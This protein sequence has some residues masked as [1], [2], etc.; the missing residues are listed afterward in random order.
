MKLALHCSVPYDPEIP[1][2]AI[3]YLKGFLEENGIVTKN[4]YWNLILFEDMQFFTSKL[5]N[6]FSE[7]E[8]FL[9]QSSIYILSKLIK[10]STYER[11]VLDAYLKNIFPEHII[12][13]R[14]E[15]IVEKIEAYIDSEKLY[16]CD[17]AG[18][19]VNT[20]QWL[21]DFTIIKMMKKANPDLKV[22]IGGLRT[23][24]Q[25]EEFMKVIKDVDYA[26][27]GEG[28]YPL[29]DF[30][31]FLNGKKKED[32]VPNFVY[33]YGNG[34]KSTYEIDRKILPSI[35]SYPFA[36]HSDYYKTLDDL[37][38][39]GLISVIP[40]WGSRSCFWHKCKFCTITEN[41]PFRERSPENIIQEIEYQSEKYKINRFIFSDSNF[42]GSNRGR[43]KKLLKLIHASSYKRK[44]TYQ[45]W[46]EL[47]PLH[48][49]K[50]I[51][52]L[53]KL[54][55]FD[56]VVVGY[57]AMTDRLL[58]KM[59]KMHKF[60]HNIQTLKLS[61]E[62]DINTTAALIRGIPTEEESDVIESL[63]NLRFIRFSLSRYEIITNDLTLFKYAPFYEDVAEEDRNKWNI[64][65]LNNGIEGTGLLKNVDKFEFFGFKSGLTNSYL[66]EKF[67][68]L[69]S[70]FKEAKFSYNWIGYGSFS[71]IE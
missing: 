49:D 7:I 64:D 45:L 63:H 11:T 56:S 25:A 12:S 60:A 26:I 22:L 71:V 5:R 17:V 47:S 58:R 19:T 39:E 52:R 13:R 3:G 59:E 14:L 44:K 38:L 10:S 67:G 15:A 37:K 50:E 2:A 54:A 21:S 27:W 35:D 57:E 23:S 4:I 68:Y 46:G 69:L 29:L 53:I 55:G 24:A 40:I 36:D 33:R 61:E 28:E 62:F 31:R 48:I 51:A 43:L 18:F 41:Y 70:K 34:L 30:L 1:N 32:D 16:D 9:N 6:S 42:A 66:W 20:Y 8:Q 65:M